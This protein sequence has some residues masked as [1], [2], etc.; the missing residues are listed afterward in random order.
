MKT[1]LLQKDYDDLERIVQKVVIVE[2]LEIFESGNDF[3]TFE[4]NK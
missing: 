3:V 4:S 1:S 2:Q